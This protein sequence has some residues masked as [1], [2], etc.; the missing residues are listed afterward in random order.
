MKNL[1]LCSVVLAVLSSRLSADMVEGMASSATRFS[2]TITAIETGRDSITVESDEKMVKMFAVT[3]AQKSRFQAGD[4]VTI[5]YVDAY[6]W[7]LQITSISG[8]SV[9]LDK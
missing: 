3:A 7:P 5:S 4:R 8:A 2:G 9:S 6:S 1:L